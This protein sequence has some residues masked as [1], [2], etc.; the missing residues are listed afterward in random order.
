[1]QIYEWMSQEKYH[2]KEYILSDSKH[3]KYNKDNMN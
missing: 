3:I 1:M 2:I